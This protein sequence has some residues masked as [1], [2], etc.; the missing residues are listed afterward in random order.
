MFESLFPVLSGLC[1]GVELLSEVLILRLTVRKTAEGFSAKA[2]PAISPA[3][4]GAEGSRGAAAPPAL[5]SFPSPLAFVPRV[6]R[7][8]GVKGGPAVSVR[9][10]LV[11]SDRPSD[12]RLPAGQPVGHLHVPFWRAV[13]SVLSCFLRWTFFILCSERG[14]YFCWVLKR[15]R[16][17]DRKRLS[18]VTWVTF[19][20]LVLFDAQGF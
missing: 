9:I 18:P 5:S 15:Y 17:S 11:A 6:G 13:C 16:V 2:P 20:F 14:V 10:S 12:L 1:L 4:E 8:C 19:V 3:H 7:P